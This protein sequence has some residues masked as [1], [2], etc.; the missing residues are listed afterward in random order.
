MFQTLADLLAAIAEITVA[1]DAPEYPAALAEV[2]VNIDPDSVDAILAEAEARTNDLLDAEGV[3]SDETLEELTILATTT[4]A[5]RAQHEVNT[6][7]AEAAQTRAQELAD[8]IRGPRVEGDDGEGDDEDGDDE[9]PAEDPPAEGDE[10]A[11]APAGEPDPEEARTPVAP[12]AAGAQPVWRANARRP[13]S[14]QPRAAEPGSLPD[15]IADWGLVAG[16]N[17]PGVVAGSRITNAA[18]LAAAMENAVRAFAGSNG[19]GQKAV[20]ASL[21]GSPEAVGYTPDRILNGDVHGNMQRI[22]RVASPQAIR[23]AGGMAAITASGGICA[24]TPVRYDLPIVG[25]DARPV[26]DGML[27]RFGADR[28]GVRVIPAPLLEELDGAIGVWDNDRDTNP[29][30]NV[31]PCL[32]LTCP[33][34]EESLVAAITKCLEVGNFRARFFPEQVEAWVRLAAVNHA[35]QA[36]VRL[37][38]QIGAASTAVTANTEAI[39]TLPDLL[40][41][42][43]HAVAVMRYPDRID[44]NMPLEFGIPRWVRDQIR[45]D[46]ARRMAGYGTTDEHY[47]MTDARIDSFLSARSINAHWLMDGIAGQGFTR[48]GDGPLQAW[49]STAVTYLY[50][51]GTHLFLDG[52][53]LDIGIQR[54]N[55]ANSVNNYRLFAETFEGHIRH[56]VTSWK[57]T[58]NLC[59]QGAISGTEDLSG[60]CA[61]GS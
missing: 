10:P 44:G 42:L 20:I 58:I 59:P 15:D 31:K 19:D 49:P 29:G 39:G 3:P 35:R 4:V 47:A 8:Q 54:D 5:V 61:T 22:N 26:R 51:A 14:T 21:G 23:A 52:G 48:Q 28:G 55:D 53:Q 32:T 30:I 46:E 40:A 13:R 11:E 43:D 33:D 2:T 6:A 50:P 60:I 57:Y 27:V 12:V 25:D 16:A 41:A 45:T 18:G 9:A 7:A 38:T 36:E 24:P 56:G 17:S 37:L 1:A 34:D